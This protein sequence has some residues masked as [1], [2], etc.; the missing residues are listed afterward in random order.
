MS[1][2]INLGKAYVQ[3]VP[4]AKGLGG[5][6]SK[7]LDGEVDTAGKSAG[8]KLSG[9]IGGALKVGL[10]AATAAVTA[11]T[12]AVGKFGQA[13]VSSFAEYQ[14]LEG[15][16]ETLFG[17]AYN[18]VEEYAQGVGVSMEVAAQSFDAYQ[19]RAS[20]VMKNADNAYKTAGL[21]ANDYMQTVTSFAASLNASLGEYAWQSAN[22]ADMAVGD[23]ADNANKMGSSMESIQ[24]A[25]QGFA[26][27]NYTMLDN[28]KLGYGGT[29]GEMERLL[30]DAEKL[31]GLEEGAFDVSNFADIVDAIHIVQENM[32]ITGTTAEEAA[33]T[34]S[35]AANATKAA[36][37]NVVTA[38]GKGEGLQEAF[39]G[40]TSAIFGEAEGE[41]LLN[42]IIP[43]I[44]TTMEG[45][46]NFLTTAAPMITEK[47]PELINSIVPP[48]ME[49]GGKLLSALGDGLVA[50][51]PALLPVLSDVFLQ[52]VNGLTGNISQVTQ[53]AN[54]VIQ[55]IVTALVQAAPAMMQG[56]IQLIAGLVQG[57]GEMLPTLIPA[58]IEMIITIAEGIIDNID[59]MVNAA[60]ELIVG[61]TTGITEALPM[62]I[63]KIPEIMV[64]LTQA[65][66]DNAPILATALIQCIPLLIE[67]LFQIGLALLEGLVEVGG[68]LLEALGGVIEQ[69]AAKVME[70][71]GQ[72]VES[73]ASTGTQ[74]LD[75]FVQWLSQLPTTLA[76]WAGYAIGRFI[77]FFQDLPQNLQN[78]WNSVKSG[79]E[80]FATEFAQKAVDM[81]TNFFNSLV[82][83]LQNL[84]SKLRA[85][86]KELI[87]AF[88][89]LPE[90][91]L[92]IGGQIVEGLWNGISEGWKWL[93]EEIGALVSSLVQGVKDGLQIQSPSKVF[94]D[95]I[96]K[97][98]PAGIAAGIVSNMAP[99]KDAIST[100]KSE[101]LDMAAIDSAM[102]SKMPAYAMEGGYGNGMATGSF[103][104]TVN[105]TSPEPLTPYEVARQT[106]NATR[107]LILSMRG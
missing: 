56:A 38:I 80:T 103:N 5:S 68:M 10:G 91:F 82:N 96:G 64:S 73:V 76:Y 83:G 95:Q 53:V 78:V 94:R 40:L 1:D 50:T 48:L 59:L 102:T 12:A 19:N 49:S 62:L 107:Q 67:A 37:A 84:P 33:K 32:G 27:Q 30:A 28:L 4:S 14:Q 86:G 97:W 63:E 9:A 2:G 104:Q 29:K 65:I 16:V 92:E 21:S 25:Y 99:L 81:A 89:E 39:D 70:S 105:I 55:T 57:I 44:Q 61:L 34:I 13:A 26:K 90:K 106:K 17:S 8:G 77:K 93:T 31:E 85:L 6:I 7:A 22:Y 47:L 23:M 11:A 52:I 15:G 18:S 51:V 20:D 87:G 43:R 98:I 60:V 88:E 58:A 100:M 74:I 24:N 101:M 75:S 3:I 36:W 79:V 41:G 72:F 42:Q 69:L 71:G 45:I 66:I 35:G 54:Q 46:G